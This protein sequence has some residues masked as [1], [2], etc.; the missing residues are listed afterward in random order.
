MKHNKVYP[1]TC[2]SKC[3]P[4]CQRF[5][6]NAQFSQWE[7]LKIDTVVNNESG[8]A[9]SDKSEE[10]VTGFKKMVACPGVVCLFAKLYRTL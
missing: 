10:K 7:I 2:P 9:R 6:K 4:L 1:L 8:S 3:L 5:K